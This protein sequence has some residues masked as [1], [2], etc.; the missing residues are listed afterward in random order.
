MLRFSQALEGFDALA[1]IDDDEFPDPNWLDELIKMAEQTGADM[2]TGP[3]LPKFEVTPSEWIVEGKFF[4]R[5]RPHDGATLNDFASTNN[6][7]IRTTALRKSGIKFN[8][9]MALTGGSDANFFKHL[10]SLGFKLSWADKALVSE[11]NPVSRMNV[12]WLCLRMFR[13]GTSNTYTRRE[14]LPFRRVIALTFYSIIISFGKGSLCLVCAPFKGKLFFSTYV[15]GLRL[16]SYSAGHMVGL[17]GYR[18]PE[19]ETIH[20]S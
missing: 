15:E 7:L 1:F 6:V 14:L 8:E 10:L 18:Y 16:L 19:Y 4:D 13:I 20:G 11:V 3:V 12:K 5:R 17:F 9:G 2:V